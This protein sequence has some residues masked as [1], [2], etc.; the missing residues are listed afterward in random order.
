MAD[1]GDYLGFQG[2][3]WCVCPTFFGPPDQVDEYVMRWLIIPGPP[4]SCTLVYQFATDK[5]SSERVAYHKHLNT[6]SIH[7]C[8]AGKGKQYV[9]GEVLDIVPGTVFFEAPGVVHTMVADPGH[10]I[11]QICVQYPGAGYENETKVVPEA[12]TLDRYGDLEAF[13][14][15]FGPDGEKYK[16]ATAGLFK[17]AR[18]MK[19]VTPRPK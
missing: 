12:G 7:I 5:P 4:M 14:K 19:H 11:L 3:G 2:E 18:W 15:T 6:W 9:E 10:S 1:S 8:I 16:A 17:S 13:L